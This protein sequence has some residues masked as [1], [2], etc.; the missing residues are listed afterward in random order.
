[1]IRSLCL[2]LAL[3]VAGCEPAATDEPLPFEPAGPGEAPDP[4]TFG[5]FP[6]GVRTFTL[7]DHSRRSPD[8][9]TDRQLVCEVWYPAREAARDKAGVSYVLHD[10]LPDDLK[11]DI[12]AEALGVVHTTAVRDA[13]PRADRRPFP[14][15]VFS[16]GKGSIRL[17]STF[18]TVP[19]ASH[20]Y[21]VVS[22]D[23]QGDQLVDLL[24]EGDVEISSTVDSFIDRP[25]D[26]EFI[27]DHFERLP[28]DDFLAGLVDLDRIGTTGHSFG[29]LTSMRV[30][31]EDPRVKA[32]LPHTPAAHLLVQ[33]DILTPSEQWG[34]PI[35]LQAADLDHTLPADD[36]ATSVWE[37]LVAPRY[38]LRLA[39]AGHFTYSDLCILDVEAIDAAIEMDVSNTLNDGCGPENLS[40]E[41][42]FPVIRH[43][44]IGFFNRYLRGSGESGALLTEAE[45]RSLAGAEV[46]FVADP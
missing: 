46:R 19:L 28:A 8:G 23:H 13:A 4:S 30:A 36:H 15:V 33:V 42:A 35:M 24:R 2:L 17:Q 31:G 32:A 5:P 45:G 41:V 40:P 1:M 10:L 6:V 25:L 12:P 38:F 14:L 44:S 29:A 21:V 34:I 7:V 11:D 39:T 20:G 43:Y 16:H 26:V 3:L 22:P 9:T 37:H 27:L 18:Y